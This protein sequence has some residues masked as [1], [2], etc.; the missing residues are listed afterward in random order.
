MIFKIDFGSHDEYVVAPSITDCFIFIS[1]RAYGEVTVVS[2][3]PHPESDGT[4]Y[5]R[6]ADESAAI[7]LMD[8]QNRRR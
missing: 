7:A 2:E 5:I 8:P 3:M 1:N 4:Y 6:A